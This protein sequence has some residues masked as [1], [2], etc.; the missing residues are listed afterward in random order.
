[1]PSLKCPVMF[2]SRISKVSSSLVFLSALLLVATAHAQPS[3]GLQILLTRG[4]QSQALSQWSDYWT[5]STY[6]NA[7]YTSV[8]WGGESRPDWMGPGMSWSRWA[9][10]ETQMPPQDMGYG[11]EALFMTNLFA[12]QLADEWNLMDDST[13]TRLVNWFNNVRASFPNT[14]L[15]HNNYG[16]QVPDQY[17]GD[18]ISR[19]QP[20]MLSWDT[21]PFH[22]GGNGRP[23][24]WYGDLWRYRQFGLGYQLPTALYRQCYHST[25]EGIRDPSPS[26]LRLMTSMALAYNY[27]M[28]C[29]FVYN[30]GATSLFTIDQTGYNGDTGAPKPLYTEVQ[31]VNRRA[32]NLGKA[33]IRLTP[34]YD[35]H[36]TN[37]ANPPPG[38]ASSDPNFQNGLTTSIM[39]L[40]GR[41]LSNGTTNLNVLPLYDFQTDPQASGNTANQNNAYYSWWEF[42]VND[43][44]F[45]GWTVTNKAGVKNDGLIGDMVIA[46]F[47]PIDDGYSPGKNTNEVYIMVVNALSDATGT[48]A[49][50]LQ[51]IKI[52][53]LVGT[54]VTAIEML[55]PQT[56]LVSTNTMPVVA[57]SGST[58]KRQLVLDLNG[59]DAALFK[60]SDGVPFVTLPVAGKLS[61]TSVNGQAN[62]ALRGPYARNYRIEYSTSLTSGSWNTLTNVQVSAA[63]GNV[64]FTDPAG[65]AARFYRAIALP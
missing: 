38:P 65:S 2:T 59:G 32:S 6:T 21:Y 63:T 52:N 64:G 53:F 1:M 37:T 46:W 12:L 31:D 15:Y 36:N 45:N 19:A 41:Y 22:I 33:L 28:V 20:D 35:M 42:A 26:E 9:P 43:R 58:T 47:H 56:G 55:D 16:G 18:F 51:Q 4:L 48:A 54:N 10:D 30:A 5:Y 61:A 40:Q 44:Y 11:D 49:D 23:Y 27:K 50:C 34:V 29:D 39:W 3:K 14:I 60:F 24:N 25:D 8:N 17:L 7:N 13:R 62:F 57:G